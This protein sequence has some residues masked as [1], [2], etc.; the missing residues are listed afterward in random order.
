[1]KYGKQTNKQTFITCMRYKER[2]SERERDFTIWL[3][4]NFTMR[5]KQ[6]LSMYEIT[7]GKKVC[8]IDYQIRVAFK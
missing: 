6:P 5:I 2:V 1:M 3:K 4:N 7:R 8:N